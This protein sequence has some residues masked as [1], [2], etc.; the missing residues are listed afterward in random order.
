[1]NSTF[2]FLFSKKPFLVYVIAFLSIFQMVDAQTVPTIEASNLTFTNTTSTGTTLN[3]TN[4]NGE[5]RIV[6]MREGVGSVPVPDNIYLK[7]DTVFGVG[8]QIGT[9]G[10]YTIFKTNQNNKVVITGLSPGKTYQAIV[11]EFNGLP[12]Y[13]SYL[14]TTSAGNPATVTT[15]SN[16]ATLSNLSLSAGVLTPVFSS[17]TTDYVAN[18]PNEASSITVTPVTTET[19][20]MVKVNRVAVVSGN[21]SQVIGNFEVDNPEANSSRITIEVTAQD[22]TVKTY[23]IKVRRLMPAPTIQTTGL[24]FTNTTATGTTLSWT[25]GNGSGR[26]VFMREGVEA[27]SVPVPDNIYF[28]EN[29]VFGLGDQIRTTGWYTIVKFNNQNTVQITGLTPG[30]TYQ[31]MVKEFNGWPGYPSFLTV[32]AAGNPATVTALSNVATLSN[33]SLST[34]TLDPVFSFGTMAY[35]A[36]VPNGASSITVT[37]VTTDSHATIKVNGVA[38]TSGNPSQKIDLVSGTSTVITIEVTSQDGTAKTYTITTE[39]SLGVI[40]NKIE[41]FVVYPNPV[42][43][44]KVYIETKSTAMKDVK[45]FDMS[46][47]MVFFVSTTNREVNMES[48]QKGVYILKVR[49]D[50]AESNEKLIIE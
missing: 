37:P 38:V 24:A 49:Q 47:R 42:Q 28:A 41:G 27:G 15:L 26:T 4:G 33:V 5:G 43:Q 35:T 11:L 46:G 2:T 6:F 44:G 40:S 30:K 19:H 34:G 3:W 21:P 20:A 36:K 16:V 10:W 31:A 12:H 32:T 18:V 7:D 23:I 9:T 45:I 14:T 48:L 39:K 13:P 8:D 1:M 17:E 22:G 25:N 29:K 50:G